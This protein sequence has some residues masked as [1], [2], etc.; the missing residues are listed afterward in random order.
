MKRLLPLVLLTALMPLL[1]FGCT[2]ED[3]IGAGVGGATMGA[4]GG[5]DPIDW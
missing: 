5:A 4:Y 3:A 1:V 2:T